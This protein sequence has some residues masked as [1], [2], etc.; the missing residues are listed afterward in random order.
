M[1]TEAVQHAREKGY[2]YKVRATRAKPIQL[3]R[4]DIRLLQAIH[5]YRVLHR[6]Q[7]AD[8]FFAGVDDEG[9]SARRRLNLLYQHGYLE[10]IPRFVSPPNN[11]PGPAY[12]LAHRGAVLL[13]E[14]ADTSLA[15]LTYWGKSED[16]D[17][18]VSK[19]GHAY[20]EHNLTLSDIRLWLE[21]A[22]GHAGIGIATWL[23]YLDLRPS[24]RTERV[25]VRLGTGS[26][27]EDVAIAPD[28]YFVLLT[29][30]GRG[31]FFLEYDRGTET[32]GKQWKRK[33]LAY[34]AY[35]KRGQFHRR[36]GV[37]PRAG[38][39]VLTVASSMKRAQNLHHAA[40]HYAAAHYVA[41]QY[42]LPELASM[43]M[44]TGWPELQKGTLTQAVWLRG[45]ASERQRLIEPI[46]RIGEGGDGRGERE[47]ES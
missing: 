9:S 16:R 41:E 10:R 18:H 7:V 4:R 13:A 12:R 42:G 29:G 19:I 33:V 23:D 1:P 37:D 25:S 27:V 20:L 24:W 8:L 47:P 14:R 3:T 30:Q 43:F 28:G 5:R 40:A 44:F 38:F 17:S 46:E 34:T 22:A 31:H 26:P 39:R 15:N 32:I 6:G 35:L 45:G 36:Y 11:N 21:H 2:R